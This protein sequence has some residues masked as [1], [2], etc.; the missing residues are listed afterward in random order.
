MEKDQE[1]ARV[2]AE[3][4]KSILFIRNTKKTCD[5]FEVLKLIPYL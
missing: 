2:K 1:E 4:E 3:V 5:E